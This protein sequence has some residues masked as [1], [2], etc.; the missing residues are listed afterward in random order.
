M[1]FC[2]GGRWRN[3]VGGV[4]Q[5]S[6]PMVRL[7]ID[8]DGMRLE[9]SWTWLGWIVPRREYAWLAIERLEDARWGVRI[10]PKQDPQSAYIFLTWPRTAIRQ[11]ILDIAEDY[12]AEVTRQ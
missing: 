4:G 11:I 7:T 5:T 6:W 3:R 10:I 12:G 2:G 9:P 1:T 8:T